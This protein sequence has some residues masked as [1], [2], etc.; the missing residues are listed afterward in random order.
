MSLG[1]VPDAVDRMRFIG[2]MHEQ[3]SDGRSFQAL[4]VPDDFNRESEY[5]G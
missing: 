3:P 1:V 2:F 5:P 4:N